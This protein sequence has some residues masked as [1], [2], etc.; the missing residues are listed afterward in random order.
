VETI[1]AKEPQQVSFAVAGGLSAKTVHIWETNANRIFEHVADVQPKGG[2]FSYIFEPESIYSLTTTTGQGKGTAQPLAPAPF[3]L[4]YSDDFEQTPLK[5]QPKYLSDQDGAFEV[6]R[7][8]GRE[9]NCLEQVITQKPIPWGPL[10]DPFS[11]AG[12]VAWTDYGVAAD[13]HFLTAAPAVVMGRID[14]ADVFQDGGARWPSG[15]IVRLKPDGA[16]ELLSAAFKKPLVTLASG[17]TKIDQTQWHHLEL[18]FHGKQIQA[19]LDGAVLVTVEDP[20]HAHGMFAIGT[21]WDKIQFDNLR[22]A[23]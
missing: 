17:C 15:Y 3:P 1:D 19:S 10:P 18:R 5:H 6:Q 4:P 8:S 14:N 11:L 12:D 23:P 7:C 20:T 22:L 16:W 2:P 13:V 21:E 9:G